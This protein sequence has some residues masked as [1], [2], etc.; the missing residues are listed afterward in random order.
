M[1]QSQQASVYMSDNFEWRSGRHCKFKNH[2]HLVFVTKYRRGVLTDDM[3]E[4]LREVYHETMDQMEGELLEFG[5][6]DDHGHLLVSAHPKTAVSALVGKLKGKSSYI[7]RQEFWSEIKKRLWGNH[8]WSPSYCVVSCGGA[9]LDVVKAYVENQ[10]KPSEK[11]QSTRPR[12]LREPSET[13]AAR[14]D[15]PVNE[16]DCGELLFKVSISLQRNY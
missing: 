10:R 5:G 2:I 9:P 4:R 1:R 16:E 3:L 12:D 11:K 15:L 8:F 14:L 13:L 7:L 6:E